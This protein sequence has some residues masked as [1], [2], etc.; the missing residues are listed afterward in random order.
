M[1]IIVVDWLWS[2]IYLHLSRSLLTVQFILSVFHLTNPTGT[3]LIFNKQQTIFWAFTFIE[4]SV[5]SVPWMIASV[6]KE[7]DVIRKCGQP[8]MKNVLWFPWLLILCSGAQLSVSIT[9]RLI[10]IK[11]LVPEEVLELFRS[12]GSCATEG[13]SKCVIATIS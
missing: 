11:V 12:T 13:Q 5:L 1:A 7:Q 3:G 2:K 10:S 9:K 6:K 8:M 4:A